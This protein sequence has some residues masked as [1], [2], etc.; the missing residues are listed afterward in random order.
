MGGQHSGDVVMGAVVM[1]SL[2]C[3]TYEKGLWVLV[4]LVIADS[5]VVDTVSFAVLHL[6]LPSVLR[7]I[8][9]AAPRASR[10]YPPA[11][12]RRPG[13]LVMVIRFGI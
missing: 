5:I 9:D 1:P 7:A 3:T 12:C 6:H 13:V 8:N 2:H 11:P 4:F 10:C